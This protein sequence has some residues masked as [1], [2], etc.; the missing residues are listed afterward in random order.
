MV[1]IM[2]ALGTEGAERRRECGSRDQAEREVERA[3]RQM[4][5][6][7]YDPASTPDATRPADELLELL[8]ANPQHHGNWRVY[9]DRLQS[10]GDPLGEL[11]SLELALEEQPGNADL[12][13]AR[14]QAAAMVPDPDELISP[15]WAAD[16]WITWRR[17]FLHRIHVPGAHLDMLAPLFQHPRGR[18]VRELEL[19]NV[20]SLGDA[21]GFLG[22]SSRPAALRSLV[23]RGNGGELNL[24]PLPKLQKLSVWLDQWVPGRIPWHQL[25]DVELSRVDAT[26][27][28]SV[29]ASARIDG[30][31]TLPKMTHLSLDCTDAAAQLWPTQ[32]HMPT[33]E[34]LSLRGP[35]AL[36][37]SLENWPLHQLHH[38]ALHFDR[39]LGPAWSKRLAALTPKLAHVELTVE[40]EAGEAGSERALKEPT[41]LFPTSPDYHIE[42]VRHTDEGTKLWEVAVFGTTV[43]LRW[44]PQG[45]AGRTEHREFSNESAARRNADKRARTKVRDGWSSQ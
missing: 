18:I 20:R 9:A 1:F 3:I 30:A 36:V 8:V 12:L 25:Q 29:A 43:W 40:P 22:G 11:I 27:V 5:R 13:A 6:L 45:F 41:S 7:G 26:L 2:G 31:A 19:T 4:R 15:H 37:G 10:D 44:G 42:L 39:P 16:D 28:S 14:D 32:L 33:L 24:P 38:L 23:L 21:L 17:G 34:S 35:H